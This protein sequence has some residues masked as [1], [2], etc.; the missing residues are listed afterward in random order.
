MYLKQNEIF[1]QLLYII[2]RSIF[3]ASE[4]FNG[5]SIAVVVSD[6]TENDEID[7]YK[8]CDKRTAQ[9]HRWK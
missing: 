2:S 1:S 3:E 4:S 9:L 7:E 6:S 8:T 5:S